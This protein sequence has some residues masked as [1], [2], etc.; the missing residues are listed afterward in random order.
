MKWDRGPVLTSPDEADGMDL[1]A[2]KKKSERRLFSDSAGSSGD[3]AFFGSL[4]SR[5]VSLVGFSEQYKML[6]AHRVSPF[7]V[8][9][10]VQKI[11]N[12][13]QFLAGLR[14]AAPR[15]VFGAVHL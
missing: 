1:K 4:G 11:P 7:A 10:R 5:D 14:L 3:Y 8:F 2:N 15:R 9:F 13:S 12:A 6:I